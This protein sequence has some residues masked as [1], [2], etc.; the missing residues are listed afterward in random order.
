[1]C[2]CVS[3]VQM[4]KCIN[5]SEKGS[6]FPERNFFRPLC[7]EKIFPPPNPSGT[8]NSLHLCINQRFQSLAL[9]SPATIHAD[10]HTARYKM[11][12]RHNTPYHPTHTDTTLHHTTKHKMQLRYAHPITLIPAPTLD[13][14]DCR[15]QLDT[16][17]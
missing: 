15:H 9:T 14:I 5:V 16:P 17:R 3:V 8:E 1:M 11:Q 10:T 6:W 12:L 7:A 4:F 2:C 13:R